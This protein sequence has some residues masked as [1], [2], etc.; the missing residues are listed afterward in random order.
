[1][2][3]EWLAMREGR[4]LEERERYGL[5][6]GVLPVPPPT[7]P[8][9]WYHMPRTPDLIMTTKGLQVSCCEDACHPMY[10]TWAQTGFV[11]LIHCLARQACH[12]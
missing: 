10:I 11:Q 2:H 12:T 4:G 5:P 9:K 1:M 8:Y 7:K 6:P 3:V